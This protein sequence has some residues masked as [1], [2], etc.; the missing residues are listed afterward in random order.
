M[1]LEMSK[2]TCCM[3]LGRGGKLHCGGGGQGKNRLGRGSKA[4]PSL[5]NRQGLGTE[6]TKCVKGRPTDS[7]T[8]RMQTIV[9]IVWR[10]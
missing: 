8:R 3:Q 4:L 5:G 1:S 10:R 7:D 6:K 9:S 2:Q